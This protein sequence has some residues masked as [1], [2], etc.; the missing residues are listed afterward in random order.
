MTANE[1]VNLSPAA[2]RVLQDLASL[3]PDERAILRASISV[4]D[5]V[6]PPSARGLSARDE[7][8]RTRPTLATYPG[9][10]CCDL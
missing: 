7:D 8:G 9:C 5:R 6:T 2:R 1:Q 10:P 4:P 3:S